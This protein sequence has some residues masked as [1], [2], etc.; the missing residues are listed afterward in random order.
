LSFERNLA[1]KSVEF[2]RKPGKFKL[3]KTIDKQ[4]GS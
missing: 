3:L 1:L 4:A 2:A